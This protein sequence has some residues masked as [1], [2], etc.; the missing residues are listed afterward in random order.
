M[1]SSIGRS[2]PA[3]VCCVDVNGMVQVIAIAADDPMAAKLD[4]VTDLDEQ[5]P[6]T[7]SGIREWFRWY[8]TPDAKPI[9]KFGYDEKVLNKA[10]CLKVIA[11][12]HARYVA[13]VAGRTDTV[14]LWTG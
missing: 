8:K 11:E 1:G 7:T 3:A 13:L 4:D 10:E 2:V 14:G 6:G 5:L 12:T 9:N